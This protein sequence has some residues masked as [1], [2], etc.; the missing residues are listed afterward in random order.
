VAD[1]VR[2]PSGVALWWVP[3]I[4]IATHILGGSVLFIV[5]AVPAVGL[6]LLLH[7]L[8]TLGVSTFILIGLS[9]VKV[10]IFGVDLVLFSVYVINTSWHFISHMK[11][12][13]KA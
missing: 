11:W 3:L 8:P 12:R 9:A 1:S 6:D 7:W 5:L 4:E 2:D 10:G 13:S